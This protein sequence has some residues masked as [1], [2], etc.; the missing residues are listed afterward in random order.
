MGGWRWHSQYRPRP[1]RLAESCPVWQDYIRRFIEWLNKANDINYGDFQGRETDCVQK[2]REPITKSVQDRINF[3]PGLEISSFS[4]ES[5]ASVAA[6]IVGSS[7][8]SVLK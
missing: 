3:R 6:G 2:I 7:G 8:S 5:G 1:K 4:R